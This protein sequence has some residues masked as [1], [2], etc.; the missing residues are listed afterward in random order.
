MSENTKTKYREA[1]GEFD[2]YS[3]IMPLLYICC[4]P[5]V[6]K[7]LIKCR[8]ISKWKPQLKRKIKA[9]ELKA[10]H[11]EKWQRI[12][13]G[14][15]INLPII[16][17]EI[18]EENVNISQK[19]EKIIFDDFE[20]SALETEDGFA[21]SW[22]L[23]E[24][25]HLYGLGERFTSFDLRG[26]RHV[27]WTSEAEGSN[28]TY[29]SYKPVPFLLSSN[30]YGI[31]V[32][33]S[34]MLLF[35]AIGK[36]CFLAGKG[37]LDLW[38]IKGTPKE[39]ISQYTD[40]TGRPP[41]IPKWAFGLW[42][43][44]CQ[45]PNRKTAERIVDGMRE[46]GIPMDVISLDPL[47]LKGRWLYL[48]DA[49]N[50][51]WSEKR[52]PN[53]EEMIKKLKDKG[54]K[55]CLWINP[56]IPFLFSIYKECKS[57][58]YL[59]TKKGKTALTIDGPGA[60]VDFSNPEAVNW[61]K[62]KLVPLLKQGVAAFKTDYGEAAP[63][64]GDYKRYPK[65]MMH[66]LYPLLYNRA[67]FEQVQ[68]INKKGIVWARSAWAGSQ[69]Y[70]LHWSG[71]PKCTWHDLR[72]CLIGG[73]NFSLSGFA[74]WSNDIGGFV[75][76]PSKELY[77]RW[78]QFGLFVSNARTHGITPREPWVFGE[79]AMRI[80]KYYTKL[81]YQL[82]PYLYTY[83]H[84][85]YQT[86]HPILRPMVFEFPEDERTF[87]LTEQYML[88]SELL[89]APVMEK[90]KRK[91]EVYFPQGKWV[92]WNTLEDF[93][94]PGFK[95]VPAPLEILPMFVKKDSIIPLAPEVNFVD[96]KKE[97]LTLLIFSP[98]ESSFHLYNDEE[99]IKFSSTKYENKI[100]FNITPSKKSYIAKFFNI[101]GEKVEGENIEIDKIEQ[102][103]NWLQ[104]SFKTKGDE[105]LIKIS[106]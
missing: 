91:K 59:V 14:E 24:D 31:F 66:N 85:A 16:V 11:C 78:L 87:D 46:E 27:L 80:F 83:A 28:S 82:I 43:S 54:I 68:E 70:P 62:D 9:E 95:T 67:V 60:I 61:Y 6:I 77:I 79:T 57:K 15:D 17:K 13:Y 92:M 26:K 19:D 102:E 101:R 56:Y 96:E 51:K 58:G 45:Y 33:T 90:G 35:D 37:P 40:L 69:R 18:K 100:L 64:D 41:V 34:S 98:E 5:W 7:H 106:A 36:E 55:L 30:G 74:Y 93:E 10:T 81:R 49:I 23:E 104:V 1:L 22:K 38:R 12:R 105:A 72:H 86:G 47:W 99:Q 89:I 103:D 75:G 63:D 21:I 50:F 71:D 4:L 65:I 2:F 32:N 94:G 44:R 48:R 53:P 97:P 3:I 73:L 29:R 20:F 84:I 88:G 25:E 8:I 39:I 52:F 76:K 42:V